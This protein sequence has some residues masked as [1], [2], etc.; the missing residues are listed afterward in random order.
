MIG[1]KRAAVNTNAMFDDSQYQDVSI[2]E[3]TITLVV[4]RRDG[5]LITIKPDKDTKIETTHA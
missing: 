4:V 3:K 2:D 1:T 5:K